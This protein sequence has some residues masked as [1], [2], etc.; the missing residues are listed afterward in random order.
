MGKKKVCLKQ[1]MNRKDTIDALKVL[2]KGL[3]SGKVFVGEGD[4][5]MEF[6]VTDE[7]KVVFKG[8]IKRD[9]VKVSVSLSWLQEGEVPAIRPEAGGLAEKVEAKVPAKKEKVKTPAKTKEAKVPVPQKSNVK[10]PVV[11]KKTA[12]SKKERAA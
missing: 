6:D 1:M 8:K 9:K 2:L 5:R 7:L 3:E 11:K 4:E 10:P 12:T